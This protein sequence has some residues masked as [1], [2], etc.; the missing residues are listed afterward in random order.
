VCAALLLLGH[1]HFE[2]KRTTYIAII[3]VAFA[4]CIWAVVGSGA[5]EVMWTFVVLMVITAM[6]SLNYNRT[7]K[8]P[9]PLDE[10]ATNQE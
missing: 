7:H 2:N 9:Y 1:G 4:Y 3:V 10:P 5:Q 6:Y 8:N